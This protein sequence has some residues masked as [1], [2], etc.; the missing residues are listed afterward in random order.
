MGMLLK[1]NAGK[2]QS[3][4]FMVTK[5]C[6]IGCEH[7]YEAS[8]DVDDGGVDMRMVR[9]AL[10]QISSEWSVWLQGGEPMM[11]PDRC[12]EIILECKKRRIP[13]SLFTSAFWVPDKKMRDFVLKTMRPN[14]IMVSIN[15]W[16]AQRVSIENVNIL[17]DLLKEDP[18]II[19]FVATCYGTEPGHKFDGEKWLDLD[20]LQPNIAKHLRHKFCRI[21]TPLM[22]YRRGKGLEKRVVYFESD[23]IQVCRSA[24]YTVEMDGRVFANCPTVGFGCE[25]GNIYDE[26]FNL[27]RVADSIYDPKLRILGPTVGFAEACRYANVHLSDP[28]WADR[29]RIETVDLRRINADKLRAY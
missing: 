25:F 17:G 14:V 27:Q 20:A 4:K 8:M 18:D 6:N 1:K 29:E 19:L 2:R 11:M 23:E 22:P 3:L 26:G 9:M 7:C 12:L 16:L 13:V 21:P 5:R 15:E 10:D 24:G 28:K